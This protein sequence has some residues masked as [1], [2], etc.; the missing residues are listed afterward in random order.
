MVV[1]VD[2][3][4]QALESARIA[5]LSFRK[6]KPEIQSND[7]ACKQSRQKAD[8]QTNRL[9]KPQQTDEQKL[10]AALLIE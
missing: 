6:I 8:K 1:V 3:R 10:V 7:L 9:L 4:V 5:D 2:L